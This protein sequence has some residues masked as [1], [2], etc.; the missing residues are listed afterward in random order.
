MF[1]RL[2]VRIPFKKIATVLATIFGISLGLCGVTY[3]AVSGGGKGLIALGM[4]ELVAMALS[5]IGLLL[6]LLV[7]VTLSIVSQSPVSFEAEDDTKPDKDE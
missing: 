4:L 5:A 3:L 1:E 6:T 2:A 7:F